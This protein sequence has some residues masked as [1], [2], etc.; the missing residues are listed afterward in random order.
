MNNWNNFIQEFSEKILPIYE[1]HEKNFDKYQIHGRLHI[2]RSLI[3]SEYIA[4]FYYETL[5]MSEIDFMSIRYA[6]A[7]HDSGRQGNGIDL[8]END[9]AEICKSYLSKKYDS[10]F[11]DF[12]SSLIIKK[13]IT[14]N[15]NKKIVTDADVLD[16]MRPVCGH[17]GIYGFNPKYLSFLKDNLIYQKI[18]NN[19]INDAW[20]LIEYT[21]NNK[22]LFNENNHLYKLLEIINTGDYSVL[23]IV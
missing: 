7:F 18:R 15:I 4:R 10:N 12:T 1:N 11:C 3:F 9:S 8:W 2:A 23:K 6:V 5:K 14:T 13:N 16:I 20:K 22:Q 17:G 19:L 21:E